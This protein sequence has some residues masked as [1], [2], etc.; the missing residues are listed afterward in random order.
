M[1]P[2]II[3]SEDRNLNKSSLI[4]RNITVKGR[5]TSIRLEPEMWMS[6]KEIAKRERCSIHDIC[7]LIALRK[8]ENSSLTASIRV[9][10]MLYFRASSTEEG[11]IR[12]RHG[13]FQNM[14]RRAKISDEELGFFNLPKMPIY[15]ERKISYAPSSYMHK[16]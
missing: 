4:S 5:R 8:K 1:K 12:S 9:F 11:H 16:H 6:L 3:N 15:M 2:I 14:V 10:I 7:T 13:D